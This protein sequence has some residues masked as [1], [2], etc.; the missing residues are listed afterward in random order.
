MTLTNLF[1]VDCRTQGVKGVLEMGQKEMGNSALKMCSYILQDDNL[2]PFFTV[3]ETMSM[4]A[5]LKISSRCM[6]QDDKQIL[7]DQIL[8]TL[9]LSFAKETRC[10]DLSGGQKKRLSIA[11][12]LIDNPPILFLD[13]PTT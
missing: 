1:L 11:L 6:S 5:N 7:I 8:D 12:E 9:H 4:A 10:S 2:Y 3:N 13:E